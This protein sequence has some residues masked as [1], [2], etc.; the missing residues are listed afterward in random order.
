MPFDVTLPITIDLEAVPSRA[1]VLEGR[2]AATAAV[3]LPAAGGA[4]SKHNEEQTRRQIER[5][6]QQTVGRTDK[7]TTP[8]V[9]LTGVLAVVNGGTGLASYAAGDMLYASAVTTIAKL[10]K[11]ATGNVLLSGDS[12]SWGKVVDAHVDAAAAIAWTKISKAGSSLADLA[13]RSAGDLSSGTLPSGRLSGIYSGVTGLG[14]LEAH[15]LFVDATY[16]IGAAGATRPRR[17]YVSTQ[18]VVGA[19]VDASSLLDSLGF[20]YSGDADTFQS[21]GGKFPSASVAGGFTSVKQSTGTLHF[22]GWTLSNTAGTSPRIRL[23]R[24]R[25][26][27]AAP[28][29]VLSADELSRV[30]T[31][32]AYES[33]NAAREVAAIYVEAT[34]NHGASNAGTKFRVRGV[35]NGSTTLSDIVEMQRG[36]GLDIKSGAL[37]VA[38]TQVVGAQGA[39]VADVASADATD[40]ASVITLANE[41]KAQ[42]NTLLARQRA[43]GLIAT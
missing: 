35:A 29:A 25:G 33:S 36:I 30:M 17:A 13:T 43:H 10:A 4:F 12:P 6:F 42:L 1:F 38:A 9:D 32:A 27:I 2:P 16:D 7:G 20:V 3:Q 26:T 19:A 39:A 15:L 31:F 8:A 40:L 11:A 23:Q 18:V 21:M 28:T 14:T 34:E 41:T 37:L 22:G 5:A 24:S